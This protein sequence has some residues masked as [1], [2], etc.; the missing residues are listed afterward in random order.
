M[1]AFAIHPGVIMTTG[2][3]DGLDHSAFG[4]INT[5]TVRNTGKEFV[6]NQPK[7]VEQGVSSTIRAAIDPSL[8]GQ[9]GA[10]LQDTNVVEVAAYARHEDAIEDL[11]TLSERLV[12]SKFEI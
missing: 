9:K 7:T 1:A 3:S 10:F 2:L 5:V 8:E 12:G 4:D 11:W 6:M